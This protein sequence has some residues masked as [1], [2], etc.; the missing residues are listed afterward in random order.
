MQT[1]EEAKRD[2]EALMDGQQEAACPDTE[3]QGHE[4]VAVDPLEEAQKA[5][6]AMQ[7]VL[8][9]KEAELEKA[10][11]MREQAEKAVE[12]MAMEL[13]N[14]QAATAQFKANAAD[15]GK[16]LKQEK[17]GREQDRK[18]YET[19]INEIRKYVC[20]PLRLPLILG[21][22]C[23]VLSLLVGVCMDRGLMT[24]ILGDPLA[25]GFLAAC[26]LFAGVCY[27]RLRLR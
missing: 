3:D 17:E 6:E 22:A 20:K 23:G 2:F 5:C 9:E 11:I 10:Q 27:E 25:A 15:M 8:K 13:Q 18:A 1:L 12:K 7:A 26:A 24:C 14:A 19:Q 21:I 4:P 16:A